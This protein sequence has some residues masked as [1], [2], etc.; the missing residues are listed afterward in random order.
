MLR[1]DSLRTFAL[2]GALCVVGLGATA[3]CAKTQCS[4]NSDCGFRRYCDLEQVCRADCAE[5][6][7]CAEGFCDINGRCQSGARDGGEPDAVDL[8]AT[9]SPAD[10]EPGPDVVSLPDVVSPGPDVVSLPD[11][12]SPGPDVVGLPD[13]VSPGPDVVSLPDVVSPGPDVVAP[14]DIPVTPVD[15]GPPPGGYLDPCMVN[16]DCASGDCAATRAG[17]RFCTR[18][19]GTRRDCGNGYLCATGAAGGAGRCVIDDTGTPCSISDNRCAR[20]CYTTTGS[21]TAHCTR[22]CADGS[23]CPAGFACQPLGGGQPNVCVEVEIPCTRAAQCS[24]SLCVGGIAGSSFRG[25]SAMC[26]TAADCPRRAVLDNAGV[27]LVL[28]P[29]QCQAVDGVAVCVPPIDAL[30]GDVVGSDR[31]G[32]SCNAT[33]G[34]INQ[35]R[36]GLCEADGSGGT[37][38]QVCTPAGGCPP[39]FGCKPEADGPT[40]PIIL[41]CRP[42]GTGALGS[43]CARASDCET[44]LCLPP[45]GGGTTG[46]CTRLCAD[47]ICPSGMRCVP[48]G[49]AL[50]GYPVALCER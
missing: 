9:E 17:A 28:P 46:Y 40:S 45:P 33:P 25:C 14:R 27:P 6:R 48:A 18:P 24:T 5:D 31:I 4:I 23:D 11:V 12:M 16:T 19:C 22:E 47:G 8:D 49:T 30:G 21:T 36:S 41:V 32:S 42:A 20:Y 13:V 43:T 7:D 26:R 39:G 44:A 37:C 2:L 1:L 50:G 38:I 15:N 10:V 3:R 29:Y 34:A 35:C